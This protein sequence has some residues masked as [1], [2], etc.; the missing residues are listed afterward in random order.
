MN[1]SH[2]TTN[3]STTLIRT[4][5]LG[6]VILWVTTAAAQAQLETPKIRVNVTTRLDSVGGAHVEASTRF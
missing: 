6:S 2:K 4:I 5:G 3:R 1:A